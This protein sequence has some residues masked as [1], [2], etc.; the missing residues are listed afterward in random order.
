MGKQFWFGVALMLLLLTLTMV[1]TLGMDA[2]HKTAEQSLTQAAQAALQG[3]MVQAQ[4]LAAEAKL[5]WLKYWPMTAVVADHSPMDE[6][7]QM[8]AQIEVYASADEAAEFAS[9]CAQQSRQV[10]A[11]SDAH[12]LAWWNLF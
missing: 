8:F 1:T 9:A 10:R 5:Q 6:I 11:M 12:R 7:D 3:D 2:I 4:V